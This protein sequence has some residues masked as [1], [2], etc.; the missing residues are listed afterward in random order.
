MKE[1]RIQAVDHVHLE[2]PFG[3][4]DRLHWFYGELVELDT[5]APPVDRPEM[6]RF[7]SER[8]ELR[9]EKKESPIIEPIANRVV[10]LVP[11]LFDICEELDEQ[12]I[13]FQP[14]SDISATSRRIALLDPAGN[15]ITL[16]QAW[17]FAPL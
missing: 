13:A 1:S 14:I 12:R 6:L 4:D 17:P 3:L 7:K 11:R 15:R 9:I 2:S 8:I 16:K 5:V 10:L